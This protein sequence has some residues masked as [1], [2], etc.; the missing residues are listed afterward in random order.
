VERMVRKQEGPDPCGIRA[1]AYRDSRVCAYAL[2]SPGCTWSSYRSSRWPAGGVRCRAL[3]Q[4][5]NDF[6]P[7]TIG[8][9]RTNPTHP[10]M[11]R[12][13]VTMCADFT[14]RLP[15]KLVLDEQR[16]RT[17]NSLYSFVNPLRQSCLNSL[18][19]AHHPCPTSPSLAGRT[20][21]LSS[22]PMRRPLSPAVPHPK[23][24]SSPSPPRYR[25]RRA[26]GARSSR[27]DRLATSS[28]GRSSSTAASPRGGSMR[29]ERPQVS[30]KPS[31]RSSGWH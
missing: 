22:G 27:R 25:S 24:W 20:P 13:A 16:K 2:P 9:A 10:F 6:V 8:T 28:R 14:M 3:V 5:P 11:G 18:H 26:C 31:S 15:E 7:D 21:C 29:R 4:A 19:P 1:S 30:H 23:D 17:V 12:L